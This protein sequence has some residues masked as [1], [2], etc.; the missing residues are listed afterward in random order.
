MLDVVYFLKLEQQHPLRNTPLAKLKA[1]Y[2]YTN[3][4]IWRTVLPTFGIA[5][6]TFN[7]LGDAW[8]LGKEWRCSVEPGSED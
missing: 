5:N 4:K 1:Q 3:D 8:I 2:R 6:V 7:Q